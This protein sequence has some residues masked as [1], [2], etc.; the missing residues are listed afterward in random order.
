MTMCPNCNRVYDESE[1]SRCPYCSSFPDNRIQYNIVY[2]DERGE[3][4]SLTD[5]EYE[6][7]KKTHPGYH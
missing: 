3:A 4:V 6:E 7:F 5:E 2:D 1:D